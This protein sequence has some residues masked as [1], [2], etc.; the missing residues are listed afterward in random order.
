M[1]ITR[2]YTLTSLSSNS[3][4]TSLLDAEFNSN[5]GGDQ[6]VYAIMFTLTPSEAQGL[7]VGASYT[8]ALL[9]PQSLA[10]QGDGAL[11]PYSTLSESDIRAKTIGRACTGASVL[12]KER[13][14]RFLAMADFPLF[15]GETLRDACVRYIKE[16]DAE[17]AQ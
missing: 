9:P 11:R 6:R 16:R 2:T 12:S 5:D 10:A 7:V 8:F 14:R 1:S 4:D 17:D 3:D 13:P 15:E